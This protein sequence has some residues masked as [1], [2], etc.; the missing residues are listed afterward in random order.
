MEYCD[1]HLYQLRGIL[2][3]EQGNIL[4]QMIETIGVRELNWST[5]GL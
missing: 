2:K 1:P 4:D 3:D 5:E